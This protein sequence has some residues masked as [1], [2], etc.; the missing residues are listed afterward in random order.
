MMNRVTVGGTCPNGIGCK[1]LRQLH[2]ET[3]HVET[4]VIPSTPS[5]HVA[6]RE[7]T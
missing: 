7:A 4:I 5:K 2:N 3:R 1:V 6:S